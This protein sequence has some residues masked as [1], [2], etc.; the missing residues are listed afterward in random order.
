MTDTFAL[1]PVA[2]W[3]KFSTSGR[4]LAI[5]KPMWL[6]RWLPNTS[7]FAMQY[8]SRLITVTR[9][10]SL[11]AQPEPRVVTLPERR[12]ASQLCPAGPGCA[13]HAQDGTLSPDQ[14]LDNILVYARTLDL[15]GYADDVHMTLCLCKCIRQYL[16]LGLCLS[17][18]ACI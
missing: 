11:S 12:A 14:A 8:M 3:G 16:C 18:G 13:V 2:A 17:F 7:P 4:E 9:R 10:S 15:C 1:G 6:P 5:P